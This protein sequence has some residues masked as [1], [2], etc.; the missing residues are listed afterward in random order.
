MKGRNKGERLL[1]YLVGGAFV[2]AGLVHNARRERTPEERER[3]AQAR[4]RNEARWEQQVRGH[5][6]EVLARTRS[7]A[8]FDEG[9][10]GRRLLDAATVTTIPVGL[11]FPDAQIGPSRLRHSPSTVS[12]AQANAVL[13][14]SLDGRDGMGSL[15]LNIGGR[16]RFE[17]TF[18]HHPYHD[19]DYLHLEGDDLRMFEVI[20]RLLGSLNRGFAGL[21]VRRTDWPKVRE[22]LWIEHLARN[23]DLA[24]EIGWT[25]SGP[26]TYL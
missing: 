3:L 5:R 8:Y 13:N 25:G 9:A 19:A 4:A 7:L 21:R 16:R 20:A 24:E 11:P 23:P 17:Q 22:K 10:E 14:L 2:V 15:W 6:Q 18:G 12:S 1:A 26:Y